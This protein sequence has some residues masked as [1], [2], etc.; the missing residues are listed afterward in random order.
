MPEPSAVRSALSR[1]QDP[2][3]GRNVVQLGQIGA[4]EATDTRI[5]VTL[6]LTSWAA[7]V[8]EETAAE[9]KTLLEREFPG[10]AVE[11]RLAEH[12][13][14]AEKTGQ[15]A[16]AAK[17]V[18]TVGSGKGGVGK[19]SV[20]A[21]LA[22]GLARGGSQVGL[23]DADVYGPSIPHLLGANEQPQLLENNRIRPID[24]AGLRVM[25]IGL[26]VPPSE[27]VIW[28]GP[29]LHSALTQFLRDT[30]WGGLDYLVIDMPPGTGDVALSISQLVPTAE[31][32]VVC[33]PQ[34][35][36]LLDAVKAVTMFRKVNVNVLGMV[37]NMS[38]F[39]CDQCQKR[40]DIFGS[41]GARRRAGQWG[42]P[43]LGELPLDP[44]LRVLA[45][46]GT[47]AS[48]FDYAP[49]R[50]YLEGLCRAVVR[51]LVIGR[52]KSP[53]VPTLPIL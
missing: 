13:R 49:A 43:F 18:I 12:Q 36:A 21:L 48:A 17:S 46:Q 6:A 4:V 9:L 29:M 44:H 41:G 20:A 8:R 50:D 2:E 10:V 51:Q 25:S 5:A 53:Q 23:L 34:D 28:R 30:D 47:L 52:R 7:L 19:S 27:A 40:H 15:I 26:L 3:T 39:I 11:V 33:T 37:E 45:D 22:C 32:V 38:Y 16:L 42:V 1:F 31:A 35:V 24:L 14:P